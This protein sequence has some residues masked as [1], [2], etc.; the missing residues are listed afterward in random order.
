[1]KGNYSHWIDSTHSLKGAPKTK[2]NVQI[3]G[4]DL[5]EDGNSTHILNTTWVSAPQ[6]SLDSTRPTSTLPSNF[7]RVFLEEDLKLQRDNVSGFYLINDATHQRLSLKNLTIRF[8]ITTLRE[9]YFTTKEYFNESSPHSYFDYDTPDYLKNTTTQGWYNATSKD[10]HRNS[11][12]TESVNFD[13]AYKKLLLN[14]TS[15]PGMPSSFYFPIQCSNISS[16]WVL[17]RDFMQRAY[18]IV[19][20]DEYYLA[21]ATADPMAKPEFVALQTGE[22]VIRV[23]LSKERVLSKVLVTVTVIAGVSGAVLMILT[24]LWLTRT[25][26]KKVERRLP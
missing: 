15:A 3:L 8:N 23:P 11:S 6:I 18:L 7:C 26:K 17:G 21:K 14:Y 5:L 19:T 1:M 9:Y 10:W 4:M 20:D 13:F 22:K 16:E 25:R 12:Y 24:A 2:L